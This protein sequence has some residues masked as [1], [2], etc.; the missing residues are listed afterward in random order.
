MENAIYE[1]PVADIVGRHLYLRHVFRPHA[2]V[3]SGNDRLLIG[4]TTRR[5]E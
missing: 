5:K 2:V 1:S 3:C 4:I